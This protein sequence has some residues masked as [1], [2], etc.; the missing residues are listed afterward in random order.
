MPI[1]VNVKKLKKV[2]EKRWRE[3]KAKSQGDSDHCIGK[4]QQYGLRIK[5]IDFE[6]LINVKISKVIKCERI[7]RKGKRKKPVN[8]EII[9]KLK[10]DK[11]KIHNGEYVRIPAEQ[12]PFPYYEM[13]VIKIRYAIEYYKTKH[14]IKIRL[15]G[16]IYDEICDF[17][18]KESEKIR[19]DLGITGEFEGIASRTLQ[20]IL[21]LDEKLSVEMKKKYS[22]LI[23]Q[24]IE[25]KAYQDLS[26]RA[27][28]F[29]AYMRDKKTYN[30]QEKVLKQQYAK[31]K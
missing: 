21:N 10:E 14:E 7:T 30:M 25:S 2:Y 11:K 24:M 23:K 29:G 9:K 18:S 19:M 28:F 17:N 27:A 15:G 4:E 22:P 26:C 20:R 31:I 3:V 1:K 8:K 12:A 13:S 16:S 6:S 5:N